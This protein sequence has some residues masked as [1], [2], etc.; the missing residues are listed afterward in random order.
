MGQPSSAEKERREQIAAIV[1]AA[2]AQMEGHTDG[3]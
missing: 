1:L 2:L 3:Q